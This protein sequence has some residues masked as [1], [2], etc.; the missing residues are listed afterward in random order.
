MRAGHLGGKHAIMLQP[1]YETLGGQR[2]LQSVPLHWEH[3]SRRD[4]Q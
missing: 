1:G 2:P 3:H 4:I